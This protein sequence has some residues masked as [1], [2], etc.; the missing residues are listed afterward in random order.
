M[1][2]DQVYVHTRIA[3]CS[4]NMYKVLCQIVMTGVLDGI[5]PGTTMC[6]YAAVCRP[7]NNILH[8][9]QVMWKQHWEPQGQLVHLCMASRRW[10]AASSSALSFSSVSTLGST[11]ASKSVSA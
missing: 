4:G 5:T 3:V 8:D 2:L 6:I 1:Q 9:V 11:S 10:R 7:F